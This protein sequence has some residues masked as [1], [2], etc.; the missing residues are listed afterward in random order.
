MKF[1][2]G[3]QD[4]GKVEPSHVFG[5]PLL[6]LEASAHVAPCGILKE[7]EEFLR[8]LESVLEPDDEGM[9]GVCQHISLGLGILDEVLAKDLLFVK[10][11]HSEVLSSAHSL[12]LACAFFRLLYLHLLAKVD[13]AE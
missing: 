10:N 12:P 4:L 1:L 9:L 3:Q 8:G 7:Q 11:L 6:F 2:Q 5:E 13:N